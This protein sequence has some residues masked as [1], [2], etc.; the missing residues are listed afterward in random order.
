MEGTKRY[1]KN[2]LLVFF[3]KKS[4]LGAYEPFWAQFWYKNYA[5]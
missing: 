5:P 1:I 4:H 3:F 2:M